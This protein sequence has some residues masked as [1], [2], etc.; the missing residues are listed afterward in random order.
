[1]EQEPEAKRAFNSY[2]FQS[3]PPLDGSSDRSRKDGAW[4]GCAQQPLVSATPEV[5][6]VVHIIEDP[7]A[8]E[9]IA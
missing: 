6:L 9:Q 2:S 8:R 3:L 7:A 1:M 5:S 4:C